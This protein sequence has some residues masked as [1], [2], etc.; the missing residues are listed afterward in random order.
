MKSW[1]HEQNPFAF[2]DLF[3]STTP[4]VFEIMLDGIVGLFF[5]GGLYEDVFIPLFIPPHTCA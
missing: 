5:G 4:I 1:W 3:G 2:H